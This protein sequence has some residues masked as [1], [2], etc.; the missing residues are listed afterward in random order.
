MRGPDLLYHLA[1]G[2]LFTII[3]AILVT[4]VRPEPVAHAETSSMQAER[5]ADALEKIATTLR[6]IDRKIK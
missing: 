4:F 3:L 1:A 6:S 5:M 2:L